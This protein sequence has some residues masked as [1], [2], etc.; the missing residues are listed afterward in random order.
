MN[1]VDLFLCLVVL[2]SLW[3]GW[4]KGFITGVIDLI[5]WMGSLVVA[6]FLY[7]SL[8]ELFGNYTG[9]SIWTKPV[10]FFT[11]LILSRV[12][13]SFIF[14]RILWNVEPEAHTSSVNKAF[15]LMPGFVNGLINAAIVAAL[16]LLIPFSPT[17]SAT[18]HDSVAADKLA[19]PLQ[20]F[21]ALLS[22]VFE[23]ALK[24]G[25]NNRSIYPDPEETVTLPF[26]VKD[27]THEAGLEM[28]M[29]ELVNTE[30]SNAG[31][32]RLNY[33]PTLVPVA[34]SHSKDMFTRGYFSHYSLEGKTVSDRLKKAGINYLS[35]GENL[36]LAPTLNSAHTGLMKSPGHRA[37]ILHKAYKR[38]GIGILDGGFRGL[39]ITQVFKN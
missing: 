24:P 9:L 2:V 33:D 36:A 14:N 18:A 21:D 6:F 39:M 17:L 4:Q 22:P 5:S 15:G 13:I 12:L 20:W 26:T 29:I 23:D 35:A 38:V 31:L 19:K 1:A 11:L 27:A 34:R 32:T 25:V 3:I 10:A 7:P 28:K 16:V 8:A 37:N 30:R